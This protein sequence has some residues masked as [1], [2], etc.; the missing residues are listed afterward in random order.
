MEVLNVIII[1]DE[2]RSIELL[3]FLLAYY[4]PDV[5]IVKTYTDP[6]EG[7]HGIMDHRPQLIIADI[8]MPKM[9]GFD[10]AKRVRSLKIPVLFITAYNGKLID[11]MVEDQVPHLLKP[12]D[13]EALISIIEKR[14]ENKIPHLDPDVLDQLQESTPHGNSV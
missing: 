11:Q 14:R 4:C 12:I 9:T 13:H 5:K 2:V 6:M 1:D 7:L 3:E 8:Q 10:L